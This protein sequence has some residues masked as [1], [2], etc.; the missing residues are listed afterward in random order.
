MLEIQTFQFRKGDSEKIRNY[1]FGL[2]WPA[3]Y[4]LENDKEI[5][6]GETTSVLAR[7]KAHLENP[8]RTRLNKMHV[9]ADEEFNKS[10]T[11]D[12]ESWLIQYISAEG[13]LKLQNG[14][15]GLRDHDYFDREKY[16]AKFELAWLELKK[17]S[18]VSQDLIQ[19]RNTDLF[20]YSP[21]KALSEDQF[22][23]VKDLFKKI[24]L[25]QPRT[26]VVSGKPGT[27]K[28]VLASY[29]VK[30]LA[31]HKETKDLKIGFV[32]PMTSLRQT[33]RKVFSKISGL[34]SN[35]V[36]GPADVTKEQY[37]LLIVDE[38]H[39][40][41]K[42][43]N[44]AN[45]A[46]FDAVNKKLNL[47]NAG[48]ELDWILKSAKQHIFF[49]DS[50]QSVRPS[51]V[52]ERRFLGLKAD[53]YELTSQMRVEGGEEYIHFID[54]LLSLRKATYRPTKYDFRIYDDVKQMVYDIKERDR[55]CGL[56]R[57]VAGYAWP[58]HTK[59]GTA[60]YDIEV[61]GLKLIWNSTNSDWVN[62][63]NAVNEVGCIHTVQG[64]DLNYAGVILGP[65]IF[66]DS[67]DK[68]IRVNPR[69]YMDINGRRAASPAEL[70]RYVVNIY[71]TLLT[72]GI[73]GTYVYISD[74]ELR[75]LFKKSIDFS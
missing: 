18:L 55:E 9:I 16:R 11:L 67:S 1:K 19:L 61:N 46:S 52:E 36:I 49:Y 57:V 64:Y 44:I 28:T 30:Y 69:K 42:R 32:V 34:T 63:K 17:M 23:V 26:Y 10:A 54:N 20:K 15:G 60:K 39:R 72:R 65:E 51:D 75:K 43:V 27:G 45:Y 71:K 3:V 12:M 14:N 48:T 56:A 31:E 38:A 66:Y 2:N 5:Y 22:I 37:D 33:I 41:R 13:T 53:A 8:I 70:E 25:R 73:K 24:S 21:Y 47:G 35:Q 40:L 4:L 6:I 7:S 74:P 58:W 59:R 50:N 62:S 68:K 29:L